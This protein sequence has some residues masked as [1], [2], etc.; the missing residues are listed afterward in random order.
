MKT[1]RFDLPSALLQGKAGG[2]FQC[3]DPNR[4]P[5]DRQP[6]SG[7]LWQLGPYGRGCHRPLGPRRICQWLRPSFPAYAQVPIQPSSCRTVGLGASGTTASGPVLPPDT[8]SMKNAS[9]VLRPLSARDTCIELPEP[10]SLIQATSGGNTVIHVRRHGNPAGPRVVLSHGN[11]LAIDAYYPFWSLLLDEFDVLVFDLRSHG[12]NDRGSLRDHTVV[13]FV[14]DHDAVLKAVGARWGN[15][16]VIGLY[17]S[18]SCLAPLLSEEL[19]TYYAGL[20]LFDPPIARRLKPT[21]Q[22]FEE[23]ITKAERG[24]RRRARRFDSI[25]QFVELLGFV[26]MFRHLVSGRSRTDC[27]DDVATGRGRHRLRT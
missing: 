15:K 5:T 9:P 13:S 17:H 18:V 21:F 23:A 11:G 25:E 16:P 10:A 1:A 27:T 19:S 4:P 3:Q 20:V 14:R 8:K 24:I 26:P 22:A 12:W 2:V 7:N 6:A